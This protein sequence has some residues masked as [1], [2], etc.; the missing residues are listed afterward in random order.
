MALPGALVIGAQKSGTTTLYEDLRTHPGVFFPEDKEPGDLSSDEVL[1]PAGRERYQRMFHR[2]RPGQLCAEA[3]TIYTKLPDFPGVPE[4][5]HE[6]IGSDLRMI[7]IVR[8]P[9]DRI[10][11]HHR[12]EQTL[13]LRP[14]MP[15]DEAIR[16]DHR[17]LA[18]SSYAMQAQPWIETFGPGRVLVVRFEDYIRDRREGVAS[19]EAF[20]GLRPMPDLIDADERFNVTGVEPLTSPAIRRVARS[21][22]YRTTIRPFLSTDVRRRLRFV[23]LPKPTELPPPPSP[24]TIDHIIDALHEDLERQPSLFGRSAPLWTEDELRRERR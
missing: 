9:I 23:V 14:P 2:S 24:A 17:F 4:R 1:T 10:V 18:Y 16:T 20:L 22:V 11:S 13:R 3:S 6:V 12:H 7:Y 8:N 21:R 5:A 15:I 19:V